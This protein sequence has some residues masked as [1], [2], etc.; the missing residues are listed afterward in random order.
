M[1]EAVFGLVLSTCGKCGERFLSPREDRVCRGCLNEMI[2]RTEDRRHDFEL[3][4]RRFW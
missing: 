3:V 1:A 2:E 4:D